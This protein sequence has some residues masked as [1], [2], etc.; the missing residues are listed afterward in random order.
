MDFLNIEPKETAKKIEDF[1]RQNFDSAGFNKAIIGLSG[2]ID[3][4]TVAYIAKNAL[5]AENVIG[6]NMPYRTS[7]PQSAIDAKTVA[8]NLGINFMTIEITDMVDAYFKMFPDAD[9]LRRGN[10]MSR[11]RM[12]VLYDQ[13]SLQRGL[14]L[15]CGN[16]TELLLGY[17]TLYGDTACA[18]IPLGDL[19]K[20][21]VRILAK[22]LG[23]P[24][25]IIQK[26]P[27]ADLWPGQ[28]DESELGF[29]Y[30]EVDKLLF[31]MIEKKYS[32]EELKKQGFNES[33]INNVS[34]KIKKAQYKRCL[35][36]IPKIN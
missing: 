20:T 19:Y 33:F 7:N 15:G 1:I 9:Q 31:L 4:S 27:T 28:S 12:T 17:C 8:D 13:S 3:S 29:T 24:E 10:M 23:V 5:G 14:V 18:M 16:K 6:I 36:P 11:Q 2:G 30:A 32:Y 34:D 22:F 26:T 35:P 21:Q 25:R